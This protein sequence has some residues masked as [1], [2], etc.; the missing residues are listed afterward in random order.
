MVWPAS[1][2]GDRR[3]LM[4]PDGLRTETPS[5]T[6]SKTYTALGQEMLMAMDLKSDITTNGPKFSADTF[7]FAMHEIPLLDTFSLHILSNCN[8]ME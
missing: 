4:F 1:V 5:K 2:V 6:Y 8:M 3:R 7:L